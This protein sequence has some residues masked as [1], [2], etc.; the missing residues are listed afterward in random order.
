MIPD[1]PLAKSFPGEDK[2]HS[3]GASSSREIAVLFED[4]PV[5]VRLQLKS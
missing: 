1:T 2:F 4:A 3:L 5:V